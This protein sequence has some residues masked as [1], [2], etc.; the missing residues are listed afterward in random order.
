MKKHILKRFIKQLTL[1]ISIG[2]LLSTQAQAQSYADGFYYEI[3]GGQLSDTALTDWNEF[4]L[5]LDPYL[6]SQYSCGDFDLEESIKALIKDIANIPD[7]FEEYLKVAVIDLLYGLIALSIQKAAPGVYEYLTNSFIRHKEFLNLKLANCQQ[8]EALLA[9]GEITKLAD[10][11]KMIKWRKGAEAGIPIH[12]ADEEVNPAEGIPWVGGEYRGGDGQEA[13]NLVEDMVKAGYENILGSNRVPPS[14][15][16]DYSPIAYYFPDDLAAFSWAVEVFGDKI[17]TFVGQNQ[18]ITG[19]GLQTQI[20]RKSFDLIITLEAVMA[21]PAGATQDDLNQLSTPNYRMTVEALQAIAARSPAQRKIVVNR[22]ASEIANLQ[23]IEKTFIIR[24]LLISALD[25]PHLFYSTIKDDYFLDLIDEL[26]DHIKVARDR[27]AVRD[28]F[29]G[30]TLIKVFD[31]RDQREYQPN[32]TPVK[33]DPVETLDGS[34][35][36][37]TSV[38]N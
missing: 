23:E 27:A 15:I 14:A 26:D 20:A 9:D 21:N 17:I 4:T 34:G 37:N 29:V 24:E 32:T 10:L 19:S 30:N 36:I 1:A 12:E 5:D 22:L 6:S 13:I 38:L 16:A 18:S 7:E 35:V 3:G 33:V 2:A 11:A 25:E 31:T 8:I 28:E